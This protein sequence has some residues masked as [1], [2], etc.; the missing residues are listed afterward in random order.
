MCSSKTFPCKHPEEDENF[1]TFKLGDDDGVLKW[2]GKCGA[3]W[4]TMNARMARGCGF[5]DEWTHP[6]DVEMVKRG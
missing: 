6:T 3:I 2:C 5:D 4:T 1:S